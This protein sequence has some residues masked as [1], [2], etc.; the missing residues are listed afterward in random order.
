MVLI[1]EAFDYLWNTDIYTYT[2]I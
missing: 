2:W 1:L